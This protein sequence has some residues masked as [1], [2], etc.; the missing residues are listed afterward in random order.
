MWPQ[1]LTDPLR[2]KTSLWKVI[3]IYGF[4]ASVVYTVLGWLFVP[5]TP[6]G[7]GVYVLAGL[8]LGIVQSVMLWKCAYNSRYPAA[9]RLLRLVVL[10]GLLT[11]PLMLYVLF[12]HPEALV[13]P[14]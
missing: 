9:G 6:T 3:W 11:I 13:P 2:G 8:A 12:T 4:T 5:E 1:A 14:N 7:I 10:V